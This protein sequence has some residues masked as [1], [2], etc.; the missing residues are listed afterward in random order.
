[1][2]KVLGPGRGRYAGKLHSQW[3]VPGIFQAYQSAPGFVA[4]G[5]FRSLSLTRNDVRG[6]L[7]QG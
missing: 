5:C 2:A 1:M 7:M 3:L 4:P 6:P